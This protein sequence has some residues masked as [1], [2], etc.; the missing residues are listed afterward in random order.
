MGWDGIGGYASD[1]QCNKRDEGHDV[2]HELDGRR[3]VE[4]SRDSHPLSELAR[5]L[6]M[7][8]ATIVTATRAVKVRRRA[9][10][11][12]GSAGCTRQVCAC[13][14]VCVC[15]CVCACVCVCVCVVCVCV[16]ARAR[17]CMC[18]CV[19]VC[20]VC[21]CVCVC[22]CARARV[23]VCVCVCVVCVR[24]MWGCEHGALGRC[25]RF[26]V[27]SVKKAKIPEKSE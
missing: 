8:V 13:V 7:L 23:H 22:V 6:R 5:F 20:V 11:A 21:V 14:C 3:R 19:C 2:E 9:A 27:Q 15:V 12:P 18:V 25:G 26:G 4:P 10:P 17:V 1:A 16:C 24:L